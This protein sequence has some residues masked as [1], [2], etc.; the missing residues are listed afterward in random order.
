MINVK[1]TNIKL[2]LFANTST[3]KKPLITFIFY[4][5]RNNNVF[6]FMITKYIFVHYLNAILNKDLTFVIL[7]VNIKITFF[8]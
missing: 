1:H 2:D 3:D 4:Q 6:Y 8:T 5:C 7:T